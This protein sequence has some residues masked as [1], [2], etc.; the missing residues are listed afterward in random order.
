MQIFFS[1][2][3][4]LSSE[5]AEA[6]KNWLPKVIQSIKPYFT[7]DDIDKGTKWDTEISKILSELNVGL[8]FLTPENLD[9]KWLYFEAGA[10][11]SKIDKSRVCP[12]LFDLEK[13]DIESP[14]STFQL[15]AFNKRDILKLLITINSSQIE[16]DQLSSEILKS[17]FE[18]FWPELNKNINLIINKWKKT[19]RHKK[20][21]RTEK[22]L[23]TE[24]LQLM[25]NNQNFNNF[26]YNSLEKYDNTKA[27][28]RENMYE[29]NLVQLHRLAYTSNYKPV[30]EFAKPINENL[31]GDDIPS[32]D[33]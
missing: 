22:E 31:N 3:K 18:T 11:Y 21:T 28:I 5:I 30:P 19:K 12:I 7:P 14:F 17:V 10:L 2:S 23:L 6:F 26:L 8:I 1:W 16:N 13:T 20:V 25:R 27:F 4:P 15:T 29:N 33:D 32:E 24:M 9:S